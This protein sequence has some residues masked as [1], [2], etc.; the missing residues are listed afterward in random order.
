[1][2]LPPSGAQ[3]GRD[4]KVPSLR[5][6]T[7]EIGTKPT[8]R[9]RLRLS[10][11]ATPL[12][13][14]LPAADG[15]PERLYIDVPNAALDPKLARVLHG[16]GAVRQV[17]VAQFDAVTARIVI[18]LDAAAEA[19][20]ERNGRTV[21]VVLPAAAR[22]AKPT[23]EST[24]A[25]T[26]PVKTA[27]AAVPPPAKT[28]P[29]APPPPPVAPEVALGPTLAEPAVELLPAGARPPL[30][31]PDEVAVEATVRTTSPFTALLGVRMAWPDLEAPEYA[32]GDAMP[33]RD[34]LARWR[35]D[36]TL[37]PVPPAVPASTAASYLRADT[38][39]VRAAAGVENGLGAIAAYEHAL[40]TA[41]DFRDAGRGYLALGF[42]SLWMGL[43]PEGHA[44]FNLL[45]ERLP[46]SPEAPYARIGQAIALRAR[47]RLDAARK[48]LD[49]VSVGLEGDA[50][51]EAQLERG[52]QAR[53]AGKAG[54][55]A[56]TL[57]R[58]ATDCPQTIAMPDAFADYAD[59][60]A[61][62][63]ARE[64]ARVLLGAAR[65]PRS[66][67]EDARLDLLRGEL[68]AEAGDAD[69]ARLAY[70][71][72]LGRKVA[73]ATRLEAE[74]RLALLGGTGDP[75]RRVARLEELSHEAAPVSLR[76]ALLGEA[77]ETLAASGRYEEAMLQL[78]QAATL[79]PEGQAQADGRRT[80]LLGRWLARLRTEQDWPAMAT[81]YAAYATDVRQVATPEDRRAL[82]DAF[83][84][85]GLA[86]PAL[87]L[88]VADAT[89]RVPAD[90]LVY[91]ETALDAGADDDARAAVSRM[92]PRT[93][94]P[95]L[96]A[97]L[98]HVRAR[99]A[100]RAG[101]VDAAATALD[102]YP[103]PALAAD[104]AT[105]LL[106]VAD[107]Q[108]SHGQWPA[109]AA[110]YRRILG[111]A[112][113]GAP[114]TAAAAGLA[115]AALAQGDGGAAAVALDETASSGAELAKRAAA[116][117][118]RARD[119]GVVPAATTEASDA[120]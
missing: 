24:D 44:A 101:D 18:E 26:P 90:R 35:R 97:R 2:D 17:R 119:V 50:R 22:V 25:K 5:I 56:E 51:C 76:A 16:K 118:A 77:A 63:G 28:P 19:T 8:P 34:A 59:A 99:L 61:A 92:E 43:A 102:A 91:A 93:L 96:A 31:L 30:A 33:L 80:E 115:R 1:M 114:R 11:P 39:L 58:V 117:L 37:P 45:V 107:E 94:D 89:S 27:S 52:R 20:M 15:A 12:M 4:A 41:P 14:R 103:D 104:V 86:G 54:A 64:E 75:R 84:R 111:T 46:A 23:T 85:L 60:V 105:A 47:G 53:A 7:V 108:A 88:L 110:T 68:E 36:G 73:R 78:E 98:G 113:G 57:R 3:E 62:S 29:A 6:E 10:G 9:V 106:A 55:A 95:A 100:L 81:V 70:E 112:V 71:R 49:T 82:A 79:G 40:R 32:H 48:A 66:P 83:R 87:S 116:A 67:E 74:M 13:R 69:A 65:T 42:A 72:V 109:A 120:R 21:T 38:L